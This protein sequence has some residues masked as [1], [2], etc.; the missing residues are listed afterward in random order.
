MLSVSFPP[1]SRFAD[2]DSSDFRR[3]LRPFFLDPTTAQPTKY[4][5]YY[6]FFSYLATQLAFSFATAPFLILTLQGSITVWARVYFYA[7]VGTL[8]SLAF[9]ASPG[10][11]FLKKKLE[12][13]NARVGVK[14]TR[15]ISSDSIQGPV[16]GLS[17]DPQKDLAEVIDEIRADLAARQKQKDS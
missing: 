4:K 12:A 16:M 13:R 3:H 5:V 1:R 9:F 7:V 10:K 8:V 2:Y 11:V 6:D 14:L 17:A 15:S